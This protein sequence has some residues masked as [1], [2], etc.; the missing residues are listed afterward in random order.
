MSGITNRTWESMI[1][2]AG[3]VYVNFGE[4]DE[5]ILGA[6][7]GGV[8][9]GWEAMNIRTPEI[10]GLKGRLKGASRITEAS[11]QM[12]VNLVE[13]HEEAILAAFPGVAVQTIS[14]RRH[15]TRTTRVIAPTDYPVNI[16]MVGKLS[17]GEDVIVILKNPMVVSGAEIPTADDTEATTSLTFVGHYDPDDIEEEPWEIIIPGNTTVTLQRLRIPASATIASGA[18]STT[19]VAA[20]SGITSGS[21][22]SS[23]DGRFEVF[24][25]NLRR[26]A[27][28]S[29]SA[30]VVNVV[31]VEVLAG[32]TNTPKASQ[33][34]VTVTAP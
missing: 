2:D 10:D 33:V 24:S 34:S 16:A 9:F 30:G 15:I 6:T 25:G 7:N 1:V 32:A 17:S 21:T 19:V 18:A 20:I 5:A 8:T 14:G 13:W 11:P 29:L 23:L 28:G 31:L 12:V 27:S 26:T 3:V 4:P 22:V